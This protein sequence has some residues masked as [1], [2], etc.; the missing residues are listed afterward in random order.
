MTHSL[1]RQIFFAIL[2]FVLGGFFGNHARASDM[3]VARTY[4]VSDSVVGGDIVSFDR[5]TKSFVAAHVVGDPG[6]FG[7]VN[8][9]PPIVLRA[10]ATGTPIVTTGE[11]L[12]NVSTINGGIE[13]GD[14]I[15]ASTIRG[16]G[17]KST[18]ASD[19]IV[20]IA[21]EAFPPPT[22][23]LAVD[24]TTYSG[25][26]RVLLSVGPRPANTGGILGGGGG[27]QGTVSGLNTPVA[28]VV[29]YALATIVVMGSIYVAFRTFGA[30]LRNSIVSVGR[31]PLAKPAIQSMVII[32]TVLVIIVTAVG[33]FIGL[34]ILFVQL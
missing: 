1:R 34:M 13:A 6:V 23:G 7:V 26:I 19:T 14:Y 12:V 30:S 27:M 4:Q 8:V 2:L 33:L 20:G 18:R 16:K 3:S 10:I 24:R 29:K 5:A 25:T 9:S 32:N 31:N 11:V 28:N 17:E 22:S 21:L 15:T